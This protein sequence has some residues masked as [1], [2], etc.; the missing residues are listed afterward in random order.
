MRKFLYGL[1]SLILGVLCHLIFH[2]YLFHYGVGPQLLLLLVIAHGFLLGP[3]MGESMGFFWGLV[4][5]AMGVSYF[6][7]QTFLFTL[8]GYVS[9]K[10]RRRVASER[11]TAQLFIAGAATLYYFVGSIVIMTILENDVPSI[12]WPQIL[13]GVFFNLLLVMTAFWVVEWW[14][15]VWKIN[16]ESV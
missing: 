4:M 10:L 12:S 7:L 1:S 14:I 11:P 15:K 16:R 8:A 3:L 13:M 6:G 2:R 9:G 5:D